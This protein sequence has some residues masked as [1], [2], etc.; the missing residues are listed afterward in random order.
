M[1]ANPICGARSLNQGAP[2]R[3]VPHARLPVA[4]VKT[5]DSWT[6]SQSLPRWPGPEALSGTGV[7]GTWRTGTLRLP[8]GHCQGVHRAGPCGLEH[9]WRMS[10]DGTSATL[11]ARQATP[12]HS[13]MPAASNASIDGVRRHRRIPHFTVPERWA[14]LTRSASRRRCLRAHVV[15]GSRRGGSSATHH[16]QHGELEHPAGGLAT[17]GWRSSTTPGASPVLPKALRRV[18]ARLGRAP[19]EPWPRR[20]TTTHSAWCNVTASAK[21]GQDIASSS[22]AGRAGMRMR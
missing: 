6:A 17:S 13:L 21:A 12:P 20:G 16:G 9:L 7:V 18:R 11:L 15:R 8:C 1:R 4:Y 22:R 10:A 2:G 5:G 14:P 19:S 3:A